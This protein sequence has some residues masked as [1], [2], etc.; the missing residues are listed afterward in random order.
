MMALYKGTITIQ[1]NQFI[2]LNQCNYFSSR[3]RGF[4]KKK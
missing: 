2:I 1:I 3:V 4:F